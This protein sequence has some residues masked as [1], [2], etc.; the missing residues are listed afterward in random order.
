MT[1]Q[2]QFAIQGAT[3]PS[4]LTT[5]TVSFNEVQKKC[6]EAAN[7]LTLWGFLDNQDIWYGH[8]QGTT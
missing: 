8:Y 2:H 6:P 7:L 5:W 1:Q 3:A 4:I